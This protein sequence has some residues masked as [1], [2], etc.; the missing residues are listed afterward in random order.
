MHIRKTSQNRLR[1]E[2]VNEGEKNLHVSHVVVERKIHHRKQFMFAANEAGGIHVFD[3]K[4][5]CQ[6]AE[7]ENE[8]FHSR[9]Y[10]N[11]VFTSQ[12]RQHGSTQIRLK[13]FSHRSVLS[14]KRVEEH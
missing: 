6:M 2:R 9:F 7:T 1:K 4:I 13:C 11:Y 5:S 10:H 12:Q 3:I 8:F 14:F